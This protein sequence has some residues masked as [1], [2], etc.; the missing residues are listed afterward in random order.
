MI[1]NSEASPFVLPRAPFRLFLSLAFALSLSRQYHREFFRDDRLPVLF[2]ICELGFELLDFLNER[3]ELVPAV[4]E[5]SIDRSPDHPGDLPF[6]C[7]L[8]GFVI[9]LV[10]GFDQSL[11]PN[12]AALLLEERF[13]FFRP[14]LVFDLEIF[15]QEFACFLQHLA[16]SIL[17]LFGAHAFEQ[18]QRFRHL[19]FKKIEDVFSTRTIFLRLKTRAKR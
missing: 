7:A 16:V 13:G 5:V 11:H 18:I 3:L 1:E 4:L 14:A 19:L 9:G 17:L 8:L 15:H 6:D 10:P 12:S 2:G